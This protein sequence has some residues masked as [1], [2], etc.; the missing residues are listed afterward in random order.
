MPA[1]DPL[2]AS[3]N[4]IYLALRKAKIFNF[5]GT[6]VIW[7]SQTIPANRQL[8]RYSFNGIASGQMSD[9]DSLKNSSVKVV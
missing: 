1:F 3:Q 6:L 9:K 2:P 8:W 7:G 5:R 4:I